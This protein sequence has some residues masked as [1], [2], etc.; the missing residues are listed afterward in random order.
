MIIGESISGALFSDDTRR[1]RY[2]LWRRWEKTG[3]NL[4]FIGLDPSTANN[5]RDDPTIRRLIGFAKSWGFGGLFAGNLFSIVSADPAILFLSQSQELP[6]G[7]NDTAIKRMRELSTMA[8]VAWGEWGINAGTRPSEVLSLI[9]EPV[10]CLKVNQ[11]GEPT[12]P[13]YLP[14]D[15]KL[16]RYYRR[17]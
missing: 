5:L 14:S 7:P 4:L 16:M 6:G 1:F 10:Y 9:G 13:L 15:T 11:S 8:L 3:D 2:A 17:L 12:H